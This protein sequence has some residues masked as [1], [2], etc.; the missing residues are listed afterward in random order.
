MT[1]YGRAQGEAG[2]GVE[3][4]TVNHKHLDVHS[5][6]PKAWGA[7]EPK[8]KAEVARHLKRGR[9]ELSAVFE[10]GG[11]KAAFDVDT[12]VANRY[13][14]AAEALA[15]D[16]PSRR[17]DVANLLG[18]PGVLV[19]AGTTLQPELGCEPLLAAVAEACAQV[20]AMRHREGAALEADITARLVSVE[21]ALE[22]V[23]VRRPQV[24]AEY[25]QRL[26]A[27]LEALLDDTALDPARLAQEV[28]L[29]A[30][31]TDI[32]EEIARLISHIDQFRRALGSTEP[33]GRTM[34]FL[35]VEMNREVNT[36]A[37]KCQDAPIVTDVVFIKGE[38]EKI[39]EQVQNVE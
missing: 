12:E 36:I 20:V 10:R 35:L 24:V 18:L 17:L 9:V 34:D 31:R 1:G 23:A 13:M 14:Q 28:A 25:Q 11:E 39:R 27:R 32:S 29:L 6:L 15:G 21:G 5:R 30:D 7:L 16:H 2:L 26:R 3:I 38:L 37:A 8:V 33:V 19:P 4:R 22:R